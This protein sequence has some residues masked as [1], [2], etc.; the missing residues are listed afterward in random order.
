MGRVCLSLPP[1]LHPSIHPLSTHPAA[2][3]APPGCHS[4]PDGSRPRPGCRAG[5]PGRAECRGLAAGVAVSFVIMACANI[6][7]FLGD[8]RATH[9]VVFWML[10]GLGLA[11][12]GPGDAEADVLRRGENEKNG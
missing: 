1:S 9:T 5:G 3:P 12:H 7:I 10:G 2:A 6:L 4:L 11:R 8:P